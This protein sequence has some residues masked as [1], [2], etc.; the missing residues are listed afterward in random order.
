MSQAIRGTRWPYRLLTNGRAASILP[1]FAVAGVVLSLGWFV[2]SS[3]FAG[4]YQDADEAYYAFEREHPDQFNEPTWD[5]KLDATLARA[6]QAYGRWFFWSV[7]KVAAL[8]C[9]TTLLIV[10][11]YPRFRK[12]RQRQRQL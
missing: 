3:K 11:A 7:N 6:D 2:A 10:P 12:W 8:V 1:Y 9:G 4:T 5:D